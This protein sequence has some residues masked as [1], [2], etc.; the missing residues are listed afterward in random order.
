MGLFVVYDICVIGLFIGLF[1]WDFVFDVECLMFF[2]ELNCDMGIS[3]FLNFDDYCKVGCN[4]VDGD[5]FGCVFEEVYCNG[6]IQCQIVGFDEIFCLLK[7]LVVIKLIVI[8]VIVFGV[9]KFKLQVYIFDID[10]NKENVDNCVVMVIVFIIIG[11]KCGDKISFIGV[12]FLFQMVKN[13][14]IDDVIFLIICVIDGIYIEIMLKLIVLD[15]VL[16]I[17]EEKVYVNVNIFFVDIILVNVLNVVI[18]IVNVFWV[19]DLICLLFQLILVIYELFVGMKM[20]FFSIFSIGV[21]G[22]FVMQGD[23]NILFGKCCIV[24]WYLVCVV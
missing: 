2:C 19:D 4:L 3:Y 18:I 23:I 15:D 17:K 20:F 24:V 10:G 6:I 5:I 16:L 8:G 1:G 22:I 9:Q 7:F 14:L 13:V 11:F 21:N 12:K